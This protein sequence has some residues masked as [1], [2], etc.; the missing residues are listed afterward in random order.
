[1]C[2]TFIFIT[3]FNLKRRGYK[4][5]PYT[6]ITPDKRAM[7]DTHTQ[8]VKI[9]KGDILQKEKEKNPHMTR[10]RMDSLFNK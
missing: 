2:L 3:Y 5:S 1:M 6:S 10:L 8:N 9:S 7:K 4:L